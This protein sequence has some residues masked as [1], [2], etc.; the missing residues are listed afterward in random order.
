SREVEAKGAKSRA[1]TPKKA[2]AAKR[3]TKKSR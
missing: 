3:S 1:N 2:T